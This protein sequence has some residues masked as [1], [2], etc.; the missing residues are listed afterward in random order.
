MKEIKIQGLSPSATYDIQVRS[1]G[2]EG[3]SPWSSPLRVNT[4]D[5]ELM[6]D[7]V[8]PTSSPEAKVQSTLK[9]VIV[10]FDPVENNDPVTYEYHVSTE[11]NFTPNAN[12][13]LSESDA[14]LTSFSTLPDGTLMEY[15]KTYHFRIIAK[16]RDG[17]APPGASAGGRVQRAN[18]NELS[19]GS[20]TGDKLQS[21]LLL[22]SYIVTAQ[23]G[24]RVEMSPRGFSAYNAD[25]APIFHIPTDENQ[26]AFF[27]GNFLANSLNVLSG[28]SI[29][30]Q[31][32]FIE[33]GGALVLNSG[34]LRPTTPL[35]LEEN[36]PSAS[37]NLSVAQIGPAQLV[38]TNPDSETGYYWLFPVVRQISGAS[39]YSY[40]GYSASMARNTALDFNVIAYAPN[41]DFVTCA[42]AGNVSYTLL[43]DP[44]FTTGY[45][46]F[47]QTSGGTATTLNLELPSGHSKPA[48][49]IRDEN[50]ILVSSRPSDGRLEF[51]TYNGT[52]GALLSTN[53]GPTSMTTYGDVAFLGYTD[54]YYLIYSNSPIVH[55]IGSSSF[56]TRLTNDEFNL[57]AF[58]FGGSPKSLHYLNTTS[59]VWNKLFA[60]VYERRFTLEGYTWSGAHD[61]VQTRTY[62]YTWADLNSSGVGQQESTKIDAIVTVRKYAGVKMT[63]PPR[64]IHGVGVDSLNGIKIYR[65]LGLP[66]EDESLYPLHAQSTLSIGQ[67]FTRVDH[68]GNVTLLPG[69]YATRSPGFSGGGVSEFRSNAGDFVVQSNGNG[70]WPF[71]DEA[72]HMIHLRRSTTGSIGTGLTVIG[73]NL[74]HFR[75]DDPLNP[76]FTY[77]AASGRLQ[78]N[79]E[80]RY[81]V[82]VGVN[83]AASGAVARNVRIYHGLFGSEY[84]LASD[85]AT[86]TSE[87]T[88]HNMSRTVWCYGGDYLI[89]RGNHAGSS[90]SVSLTTSS[91]HDYCFMTVAYG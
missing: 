21:V 70:R 61:S 54:N 63:A 55:V 83:L 35:V 13:L 86:T 51:R 37:F 59:P 87:P 82:S 17:A 88:T 11:P 2:R 66:S 77:L 1:I 10:Y 67:S 84:E 38:M 27:K 49:C 76:R 25:G 42:N 29:S 26:D 34:N 20:I 31:D 80:G 15:D 50:I 24:A 7:G 64:P 75:E 81:T 18:N 57:G 43:S 56:S 33:S 69:T 36:Y 23:Q 30:G 40:I 22:S 28:M 32:N 74:E 71:Q 72:R 45:R 68:A 41:R 48:M 62:S 89:V 6:S 3:S 19:P 16:D 65:K 5:V 58:D 8:P 90:G 79:R 12:T 78:I 91:S 4:G 46:V 73:F 44:S 53:L 52:T 47:K 39:H 85:R 60:V 9:A 14:T